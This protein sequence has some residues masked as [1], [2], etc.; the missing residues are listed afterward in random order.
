MTHLI[1]RAPRRTLLFELD[2]QAYVVRLVV[3]TTEVTLAKGGR[4]D[5]REAI[6]KARADDG[7]L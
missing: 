7:G 6:V 4:M 5:L 3:D 2:R 1:H